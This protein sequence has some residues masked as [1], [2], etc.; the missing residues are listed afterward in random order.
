MVARFP[1]CLRCRLCDKEF[2]EIPTDAVRILVKGSR[3]RMYRFADGSVHDIRNIRLK[4][5]QGDVVAV[6]VEAPPTGKKVRLK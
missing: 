2:T 1:S 5:P 6:V 3:A 4:A